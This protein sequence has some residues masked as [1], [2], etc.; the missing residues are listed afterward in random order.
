MPKPTT[1]SLTI[2]MK[3]VSGT[4]NRFY[5]FLDGHRV[6]AAD[7]NT[8]PSLSRDVSMSPVTLRVRVFGIDR[9]SYE[10]SIDLPGTADDQNLKLQ[11]FEG[12]H[13]LN[14]SL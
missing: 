3:A 12:Y 6:I 9:A 4:I 8:E 11:L 5:A 2:A 13:E 14:L 7:G 10:L 1:R